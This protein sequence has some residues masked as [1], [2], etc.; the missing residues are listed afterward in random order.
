MIVFSFLT[1]SFIAPNY[2]FKLFKNDD[3]RNETAQ[4]LYIY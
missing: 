1:S 4:V 2:V 3:R